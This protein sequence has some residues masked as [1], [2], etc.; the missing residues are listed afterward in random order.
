MYYIS[1]NPS[2]LYLH[3]THPYGNCAIET[4]QILRNAETLG[5]DY[6]CVHHNHWLYPGHRMHIDGFTHRF[7]GKYYAKVAYK[8]ACF[9]IYLCELRRSGAY[10]PIFSDNQERLPQV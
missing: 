5:A 9:R 3:H 8:Q 1:P 2:Q 7:Q 6:M 10:I 4:D